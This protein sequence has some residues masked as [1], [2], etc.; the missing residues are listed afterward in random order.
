MLLLIPLIVAIVAAILRGG[1]LRHLAALPIRGSAFILAS[2][3]IQ[4][5]LYIPPFRDAALVV[6][7]GGLIYLVALALALAGALSNWRLGMAVRL[8]TLGLALNATVIAANG[9]SMPVNAQ[10]M[11]FVQGAGKVRE[12]ADTRY[13]N[14][15]RLAGRDARLVLLSDIIPAPLPNGRGNV[16]SIGDVLLAAGIALLG[17][18]ATLGSRQRSDG[19][20]TAPSYW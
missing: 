20:A 19:S 5:L 13:Y 14:N 17:Y 18:Q 9:G 3:A 8:A 15:T 10:A 16:Y 7:N 4:V 11:R 6:H 1:S 2:L 12:I